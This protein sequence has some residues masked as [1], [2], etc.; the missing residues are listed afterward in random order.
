MYIY[1]S[2][3]I[4]IIAMITINTRYYKFHHTYCSGQFLGNQFTHQNREVGVIKSHK[5]PIANTMNYMENPK[6][7]KSRRVR[8]KFHY[9]NGDYNMVLWIQVNFRS[10]SYW[11]GLLFI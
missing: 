8:E 9:V 11:R 10:L 6:R 5:R 3:C 2:I 7:E 4:Y 1:K